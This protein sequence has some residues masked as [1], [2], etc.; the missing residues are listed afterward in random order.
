MLQREL[1][2]RN[3]SGS[4]ENVDCGQDNSCNTRHVM[5]CE[6]DALPAY[7]DQTIKKSINRDGSNLIVQVTRQASS[8]EKLN[9]GPAS[10]IYVTNQVSI[11]ILGLL[12]AFQTFGLIPGIICI[13]GLG[14]ESQKPNTAS[15]LLTQVLIGITVMYA[16]YVILQFFRRYPSVLSCVDCFKIIGG[17]PLATVVG[18]WA[19]IQQLVAAC[20]DPL[21]PVNSS[22]MCADNS[23]RRQLN[24]APCMIRRF[25]RTIDHRL[26]LQHVCRVHPAAMVPSHVRKCF[27]TQALYGIRIY[28]VMVATV[29]SL[30]YV[31]Q[32]YQDRDYMD[33]FKHKRACPSHNTFTHDP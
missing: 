32:G 22:F 6:A 17:T 24:Q 2:I 10:L 25:E 30:Y 11:G 1:H 33:L 16:A 15:T 12:A 31:V 29:T 5:V 9:K 20:N 3:A 23:V 26:H 18:M 8:Y 28:D 21:M 27:Y 7:R 4:M 14:K 19:S 13:I